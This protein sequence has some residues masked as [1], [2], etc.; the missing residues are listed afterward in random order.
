VSCDGVAAGA[1]GAV[2]GDGAIEDGAGVLE[3]VGV[4]AAFFEVPEL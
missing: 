2:E 3:V 1:P 4:T